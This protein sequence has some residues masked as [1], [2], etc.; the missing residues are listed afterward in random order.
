MFHGIDVENFIV[1]FT[2]CVKYACVK[3]AESQCLF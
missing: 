1:V 2:G 3:Q